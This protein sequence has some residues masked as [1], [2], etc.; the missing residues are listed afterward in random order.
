MTKAEA[1]E[2]ATMHSLPPRMSSSNALAHHLCK[3]RPC[4]SAKSTSR[5]EKQG[6]CV[7]HQLQRLVTLSKL[8][9]VQTTCE[10]RGVFTQEQ[11]VTRGN[12]KVTTI[13]DSGNRV[14]LNSR[15]FKSKD[16]PK[17]LTV[18]TLTLTV[19][20]RVSLLS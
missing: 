2:G 12:S 1:T 3:R 17:S 20:G 5:T 4:N 11:T 8:N 9:N 18:S 14:N 13:N 16:E 7:F 6:Y 15:C 19:T 10:W